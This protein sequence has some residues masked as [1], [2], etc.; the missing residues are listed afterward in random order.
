MKL[1]GP[2]GGWAM[3]RDEKSRPQESAEDRAGWVR[4]ERQVRPTPTDG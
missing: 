2:T 4:V 3:S 1:T